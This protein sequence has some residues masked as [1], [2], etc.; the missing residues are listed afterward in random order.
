M[1]HLPHFPMQT[2]LESA[3]Q[4]EPGQTTFYSLLWKVWSLF[5]SCL[6]LRI[7]TNNC[8]YFKNVT[9]AV[10]RFKTDA[11]W[12]GDTPRFRQR[13]VLHMTLAWNGSLDVAPHIKLGLKPEVKQYPRLIMATSGEVS[14]LDG[15]THDNMTLHDQKDWAQSIKYGW[16]DLL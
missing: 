9:N 3:M 2:T 13:Q 4:D 6:V 1:V 16:S 8:V 15:M 5:G 7:R 10:F 12:H 11:S 14:G